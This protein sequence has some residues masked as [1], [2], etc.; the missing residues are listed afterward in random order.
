MQTG[1]HQP[2]ERR[3]WRKDG[4]HRGASPSGHLAQEALADQSDGEIDPFL[5][6]QFDL[7]QPVIDSLTD[8][9]QPVTQS[10]A[11]AM[12]RTL[13][14]S[15]EPIRQAF[16]ARSFNALARLASQLRPDALSDAVGEVSDYAVL[17]HALEQPSALAVLQEDDPH[18][19]ARLRDLELR[20]MILES[21]GG[22]ISVD[23][24]A[25]RLGVTRQAV[26][27][28]RRA[29]RLL[30]LPIGFSRYAYPVWQFGPS[31]MLPGFEE[32]LA[33]LSSVDPW[34]R[35][36]FFLG[37]NTYL[38]GE[39]PL[40]EIRRGNVERVRRAAWAMGEQGAA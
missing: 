4:S 22:T 3:A 24:V 36:A 25:Q 20:K 23:E 6:M 35:A 17:L 19:E 16:L 5:R 10:L 12:A 40:D 2:R 7:M 14:A 30:A 29:G 26:D 33:E 9:R 34:T 13:R 37:E 18:A 1:A 27:K 11:E 28:R 32:V 31:G 15:Q 8:M 21:D 39:R 38:D